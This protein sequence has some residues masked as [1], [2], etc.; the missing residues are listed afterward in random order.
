MRVRKTVCGESPPEN[1][2]GSTVALLRAVLLPAGAVAALL[3]AA[4]IE[5][6]VDTDK[7]DEKPLPKENWTCVLDDSNEPDYSLALG[8]R[9]DFD[10][11]ASVPLDASISGAKSAKTV[12]DQLD[13]DLPLYFQN[14]QKYQIH[15]EFTSQNLSGGTHPPVPSL[16]LFNQTEYYTPD[17]RFVLGA[18]TYYDGPGVWTYEIAPYDNASPEMITLA[19]EKITDSTWFGDSLYFHPTSATIENLISEL[20]STIKIITTDELYEGTDYQPLNYGTAVGRLVFVTAKELETEY[21][22]F[23]D[24]VVLDEVPNDISVTCGI[25]TQMFQ[26]PLAH[27]N[28]L[29]QNRG[30][31]NMGLRG[32][33]T[34]EELR[35]L[36]GKWVSL[37]VG[38]NAYTVT[39]VS[40]DSA[41]S[42]WEENRPST[43]GIA[44]LD[45]TTREL[46]DIEDILDIDS[47]GKGLGEALDK[48]IPAYGGKAS[49]F[50][51]FPHMDSTK[52]PYPKAF[53]VPVYYYWQ[54]MEENGFNALVDSLLDDSAFTND[55]S[56]RDQALEELRSAIVDAPMNGA[57]ETKLFAKLASEFEATRMRF[58]SSTNAEDLDG[59]TGAGL[60]TSKSGDTDDPSEV[61]DAIRKVWSSVWYFRAF[62]ERSYR[63]IDH[64]S[65]GMA[66][67]VHRSF[68][69]EE[70]N[71]VAI[72]ANIYDPSG[73]EPGFYINA[74][75]GGISVVLPDP[76]VT[77]DQIIYH[78]DMVGQPIVY[79]AHSNLVDSGKTVLTPKQVHTLGVALTEIHRFFKPLYGAE[80]GKWYAMDTEFK[81]DQPL[82]DPDSEPVLFM[83]QARPYPGLGSE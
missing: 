37:T 81:F 73:M 29:S 43:V 15:W 83:K 17:R 8:C 6:P 49:H 12:I 1:V 53:G 35:D 5:N 58:R 14:S 46:R 42:W 55:P 19:Y 2:P 13:P 36:E 25:I 28:V 47:D 33:F 30:T 74:Q 54:F 22:G 72:T 10:I 79:M 60:Y 9:E 40:A 24:I 39:E 38:G 57:F 80:T 7:P 68:P 34:N 32:A 82:D 45:T 11:L 51:A 56:V 66:L 63:N 70:A 62:E 3:T 77:T 48:A 27:I 44:A 64:R 61:R 75:Q 69:S 52:V 31:P 71:G 65:V 23:R 26:T 67:L 20:P 21:V 41:E 78:Y 4:C 76:T 50:A 16:S 18:I 59:F